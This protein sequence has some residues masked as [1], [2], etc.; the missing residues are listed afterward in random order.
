MRVLVINPIM[1][2]SE[3]KRIQRTDTIK[4]T[5]MYD[6]CLAFHE[7]GHQ[8]TLVGGEPFKPENDETYPF[9]VLW[10]ECRGQKLFM[11]HCLPFMPATWQYVKKG[12]YDL[13]LSS[14]VFS[15]NSLMAY[16]AAPE[17]T[18]IWHELAKHNAI[19]KQ[20]PSK[21]WYN[22]V[23]RFFMRNVK[24][25]A[26]SKEAGDFIRKYCRNTYG[27]IIDHGVNLDKFQ[28]EITK[29]NW[30][31]VCSQLIGRKRIDGILQRFAAYLEKYDPDTRLYIAGDGERK[32]E[33]KA[34][35]KK[36]GIEEKV[37]FTGKISHEELLPVL[38]RAKALLVNTM[39]DNNMVSIVESIAVGTP[40][41]TTDVPL[42][43]A[44]I[45][46]YCLGIAKKDW[47]EED[48]AKI[49]ENN[50]N[51][52]QNCMNYRER[53]STKARVEQFMEISGLSEGHSQIGA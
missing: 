38:S 28:P 47:D 3:T 18:I 21:V 13:I 35:A 49:V 2:T 9:E 25:V 5:M 39:K 17:K 51:Y 41:V 15:L 46:K 32:E 12:S 14:E 1:Y 16:W 7:S 50:E 10:W 31:V 20:I 30:F 19:M 44:Y 42:N 4:D 6:L 22:F 24:V 27:R 11:P 48:L 52:V 34:L 53:L 45:K 8:V 43:S 37:V 26:R 40:V 29:N 36:M 23:A 33:L